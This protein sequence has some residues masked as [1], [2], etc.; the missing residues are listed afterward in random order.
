MLRMLFTLA[1][2][3]G[4]AGSGWT[5]DAPPPR[6]VDRITI[7]TTDPQP[8]L[9]LI[10]PAGYGAMYVIK[11][12]GTYSCPPN[13][14]ELVGGDT[15]RTAYYVDHVSTLSRKNGGS[16]GGWGPVGAIPSPGPWKSDEV[17]GTTRQPGDRFTIYVYATGA[18]VI[19]RTNL[20]TGVTAPPEET[21]IE[22]MQEFLVPNP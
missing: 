19:T 12:Q 13:T 8:A 14:Q 3:L 10:G 1:V 17:T 18:K 2:V 9:L 6:P 20:I 16:F 22:G 4:L 7:V 15:V 11:A 5:E 21:R